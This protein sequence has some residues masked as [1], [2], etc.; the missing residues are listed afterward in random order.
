[1]IFQQSS[2]LSR[3]LLSVAFAFAFAPTTTASPREEATQN[4]IDWIVSSEG[5]EYN[6]KQTEKTFHNGKNRGIFANQDIP[7]GEILLRVPWDSI[8]GSNGATRDVLRQESKAREMHYELEHEG[9]FMAPQCRVIRDL[10]QE[11][12]KE[13]D[14]SDFA[15]YLRYLSLSPNNN[16]NSDSNLNLLPQIPAMWSQ[17]ARDL[18]EDMN[19]HGDL[20][21]LG[22]FT[23]LNHNWFGACIK[24]I[25]NNPLEKKVASTVAAHG[26]MGKYGILVPLIDNYHYNQVLFRESVNAMTVV[27]HGQHV[28]LVAIEDISEGA[29]IIRSY[30][31][32][33]DEDSFRTLDMF[34]ESG[35]IDD[36]Y[37]PK[38]YHFDSF[39]IEVYKNADGTFEAK[40]I[41]YDQYHDD[42]AV[43]EF[44]AL[45]VSRLKRIEWLVLENTRASSTE[46]LPPGS[47]MN[48][49]EW[50]NL[51]KYH[52]NLLQAMELTLE[53]Y[54]KDQDEDEVCPGGNS[55]V[56]STG[57]CP[58]WDSFQSLPNDRSLTL[59]AL[60]FDET[61]PYGPSDFA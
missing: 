50:K 19:D 34:V 4:L 45:E 60:E 27:E 42:D 52:S 47:T 9:E 39:A 33:Q 13:K 16:S 14:D 31:E 37:Y 21:P 5:G 22:L 57:S 6:S 54:R 12:Q 2:S 38:D 28:S 8:L 36:E 25:E 11:A 30:G 1:M 49:A 3:L 26:S 40:T 58:I 7:K 53:A 29:E 51:W 17:E 23:T 35:I 24:D 59:E 15:I 18:L 55:P 48:Q 46:E 43:E 61:N 32:E 56:G 41:V 10:Y 44:F 20:P